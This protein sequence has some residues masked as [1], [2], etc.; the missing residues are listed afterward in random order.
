LRQKVQ[1]KRVED[2]FL[3]P[4]FVGTASGLIAKSFNGKPQASSL[5]FACV[6]GSPLNENT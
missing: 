6:C 2:W 5:D 1:I 4:F 3:G